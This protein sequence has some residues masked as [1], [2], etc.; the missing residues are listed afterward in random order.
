MF[1]H[2]QGFRKYCRRKQHIGNVESYGMKK[3]PAHAKKCHI[4]FI[5]YSDAAVIKGKKCVGVNDYK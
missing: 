4:C 1:I 2:T 3:N 5:Y